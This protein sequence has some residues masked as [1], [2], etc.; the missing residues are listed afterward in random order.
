[1]TKTV[2]KSSISNLNKLRANLKKTLELNLD[3]YGLT[4]QSTGEFN[5]KYL[6][7]QLNSAFQ[8]IYDSSVGELFGHEAFL[9]PSLGGELRTTS[10]FAFSYAEHAGKLVQFD[11]VSR[12]LHALNF[13]QIYKENGLLFINVHPKLLISVNEHGK[14]FESIL[15]ANSVPT[16]RVVIQI[17]EGLVEQDNLLF[18][19][20]ENYKERGYLIAIDNFGNQK[21]HID[22]LWQL[23]PD[24]VKI[25]HPLIQKAET[26]QRIHRILPGLITMIKD[27]GA[28]PIITGIESQLQLD[29][30][31]QIGASLL[32]GD[33]LSKAE[34][35]SKLQP[36]KIFKKS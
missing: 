28:K 32:Q 12:T 14:I 4:E 20:I 36:S 27:V 6:G 7:V 3:D 30:A 10:D 31:N 2:S 11:R 35:A 24:F 21:S 15:H 33:F 18:K 19:A 26:N 1:M 25:D 23:T 8:A 34:L 17:K 16:K 13:R 5:S 29:I 9:E 22:R